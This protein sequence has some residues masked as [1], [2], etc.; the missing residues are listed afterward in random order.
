[1]KVYQESI[2]KG[3][4]FDS[5]FEFVPDLIMLFVSP[6][7]GDPSQVISKLKADNPNSILTGCSTSGHII[8]TQVEDNTIVL[9]AIKFDNTAIKLESVKL[10]ENRDSF[11]AGRTLT[12][13]LMSDDL[14]HIL[15]LSDGLIVN[16]ADLVDGLTEGAVGQVSITGGL[17]GDGT[18]FADTFTICDGTVQ[19]GHVIGIGMYGSDL[20]VHYSSMGGWDTF[21]LERK[22]TSSN[23]N[24]LFELDG[25][26]ALELYKS[27]L[28]SRA[29]DLPGSGLL[30]PLSMRMNETDKPIVRTILGIDEEN[31]SL[32]F[33]GNIPEGSYVR[34]M[35]ANVD[36]LIDGAEGSA[37]NAKA[38]MKDDAEF[39]LLISCV[40]RRLV[41]KQI[42]EE[43]IEVVRNVLGEKPVISGFYSY[44]ELAPFGQEG[45]CQL[46]NQTMTITTFSESALPSS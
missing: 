18:D 45:P 28:G 36:R 9:N 24:I 5:S 46:H 4:A 27:F 10:D 43:E 40:G 19:T 35:K 20:Q 33:A 44:G 31:N 3:A 30:F 15:I 23:K 37:L 8:N 11:A 21:G 41:L 17:A 38:N 2:K 39:A 34:L 42:V 26:P 7:Y 12:D 32:T 6:G 1:M 16:G 13:K 29:E 14:R 25:M 22:V